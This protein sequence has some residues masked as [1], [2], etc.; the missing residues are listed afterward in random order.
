MSE[1][2]RKELKQKINSRIF[3]RIFLIFGEEKMYVKADCEYLVEKLCG[4]NPTEFNFHSFSKDY[5]LDDIAVAVQV[6][7]FMSEYNVVVISDYDANNQPK[8]D[9]DRLLAILEN[10]SDGCV[11][12]LAYPTLEQDPKKLGANFKSIYNYVKK[13]GTVCQNNR[14]TDIS[15]ARQIVRWADK[16]SIKIEQADAY[17]LQE[18][19]GDDLYTIKNELD[20]LCNYVGDGGLITGAE[21]ELLVTK[22]LEA[23]IF[24]LTDEIVACNSTKAFEILDT[25]FYQKADSNEIISVISMAYMDFYRAR[26]AAE[27]AVQI[28]VIAKDFG[29]GR[30]EFALKNAGRKTRNI[31]TANLRDSIDEI[32]NT[33]AR[34]RSTS[35]NDRIMLETLVAKLI[36]LAGKKEI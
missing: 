24:K 16:R 27:C 26:V 23:N 22:R 18:Y 21:I 12:I 25:L 3:D 35:N 8:S 15:L 17:K 36:M 9:V 19:V 6:V 5:D 1:I 11:V 28:S 13:H 2:N 14:E 7:P 34:L 29:Y 32:I 30:R 4:K 20:K 31:S 33:T 10:V